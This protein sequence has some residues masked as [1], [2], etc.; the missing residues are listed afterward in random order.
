MSSGIRIY[1]GNYWSAKSPA[2]NF[3]LALTADHLPD[4]AATL[5]AVLSERR[6]HPPLDLVATSEVDFQAF[7][8]AA[9]DALAALF[10]SPDRYRS[11]YSGTAED[12][13][14]CLTVFSLLNAMLKTDPRSYHTGT[15]SLTTGSGRTWQAPDTWYDMLLEHL[16]ISAAKPELA[17]L[18]LDCA[19]YR[20]SQ[21]DFSALND[22]DF[23]Q[24]AAALNGYYQRYARYVPGM[25]S[26]EVFTP[27]APHLRE[28]YHC[29][30]FDSRY[31]HPLMEALVK[32]PDLEQT[33]SVVT[34]LRDQ[35]LEAMERNTAGN[36]AII[37]SA[38]SYFIE[39]FS[40]IPNTSAESLI[41][42]VEG[43]RT[44]LE[45]FSKNTEWMDTF[46]SEDEVVEAVD[47]WAS[48]RS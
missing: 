19:T 9:A 1:Q 29:M 14:Q 33:L 44:S 38:A 21:G 32:M 20:R 2:Y 37:H 12:Y 26:A 25:S 42:M 23:Y 11:L 4:H 43:L 30:F 13:R 27:L 10:A 6:S 15:G 39:Y 16:A 24:L 45:N 35:A 3:I 40:R 28:L 18:I 17:A 46:P 36:V 22:E 5:K 34:Y 41:N 31:F 8:R 48:A 7:Q 47:R